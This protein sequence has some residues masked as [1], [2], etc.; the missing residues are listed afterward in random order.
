MK[1]STKHVGVLALTI[2]LTIGLAACDDAEPAETETVSESEQE[3]QENVDAS[4]DAYE[5][6]YPVIREH[7]INEY[8]ITETAELCDHEADIATDFDEYDAFIADLMQEAGIEPE[9]ESR[10]DGA[11]RGAYDAT[12]D[13]V[14]D[15]CNP[16]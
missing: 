5:D 2:G 15:I 6:T 12:E 8:G 14:Y 10:E 3:A 1:K 9:G 7:L 16:D 11:Y 13:A 4:N